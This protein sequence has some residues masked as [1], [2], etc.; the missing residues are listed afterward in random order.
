MV[1]EDLRPSQQEDMAEFLVNQEGWDQNQ[2]SA[3]EGPLVP[4]L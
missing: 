1:S 2:G 4:I 3:F